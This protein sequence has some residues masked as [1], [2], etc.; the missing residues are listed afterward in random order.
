MTENVNNRFFEGKYKDLWREMNPEA[1]TLKE[2]EFIEQMSGIQ[3]GA[4]VLDFM[5]GYGRHAI[6]LSK[7]GYKVTAVDNLADYIREITLAS[8]QNQLGI[9]TVR[10]DV[11]QY[12]A[13]DFLFDLAINMGNSLCFFNEEDTI[14]LLKNVAAMLKPGGHI[15]VNTWST[16]EIVIHGFQPRTWGYVGETKMLSESKYLFDPTRVETEVT[17]IA[18]DGMIETKTAIDYIFTLDQL[19]AMFV[20]AGFRVTECWA[21]PGKKK[22]SFGDRRIYLLGEKI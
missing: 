4:R 7:K 11:M 10:A 5:C 22:Y 19:K 20:Q 12:R 3:Q 9:E 6:E 15:I 1:L 18:H 16:A 8:E 14:R 17:M 13:T 2:T 21:I